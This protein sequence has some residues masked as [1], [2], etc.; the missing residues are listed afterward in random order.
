MPDSSGAGR[1]D[2]PSATTART[3]PAS[4]TGT[5]RHP[6]GRGPALSQGHGRHGVGAKREGEG[7]PPEV[8]R[9]RARES[10]DC[11]FSLIQ[12]S[13]KPLTR[14]NTLCKA[15]ICLRIVEVRAAIPARTCSTVGC[16]GVIDACVVVVVMVCLLFL[17][18]SRSG[19]VCSARG[20]AGNRRGGG[21]RAFFELD[22]HVGQGESFG[23][24]GLDLGAGLLGLVQ[25]GFDRPARRA[26]KRRGRRRPGSTSAFG[27]R[28]RPRRHHRSRPGPSRG[29]VGGGILPSGR[30]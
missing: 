29:P 6:Q 26:L 25:G 20:C 4:G 22:G 12:D 23:Q 28:P 18:V 5:P 1:G 27:G 10:C 11:T 17:G 14:L 15:R 9:Q 8:E 24:R 30:G 3:R 13:L 7:P 19:R 16:V 21:G 2:G